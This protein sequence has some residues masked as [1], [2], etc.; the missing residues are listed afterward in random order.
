MTETNLKTALLE[1]LE[2]ETN[3]MFDFRHTI[4][5]GTPL[6]HYISIIEKPTNTLEIQANAETFYKAFK[7]LIIRLN[8]LKY[9]STQSLGELLFYL[10]QL[11]E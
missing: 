1:R 11:S 2:K 4:K 5:T 6:M 3:T 7:E 10:F 9:L 8:T